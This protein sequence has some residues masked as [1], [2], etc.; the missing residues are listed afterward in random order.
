MRSQAK[1]VFNQTFPGSSDL[2]TCHSILYSMNA[3][4]CQVSQSF[5]LHMCRL[6]PR[7]WDSYVKRPLQYPPPHVLTMSAA[8]CSIPCLPRETLFGLYLLYKCQKI[9]PKYRVDQRLGAALHVSSFLRDHTTY[10]PVFDKL[11]HMFS[12]AVQLFMEGDVF[13]TVHSILTTNATLNR[14]LN[15]EL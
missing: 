9:V 2:L 11:P 5:I 14:F 6:W 13:R 15:F 8:L 10:C 12:L 3:A 1:W 7:A 4:F